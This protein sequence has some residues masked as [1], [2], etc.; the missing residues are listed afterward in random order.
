M[1]TDGRSNRQKYKPTTKA[2]LLKDDGVEIF[3]FG[4]RR[5]INDY[6]LVAIAQIHKFQ[7]E[8]FDDLSFLSHLISSEF[9]LLCRTIWHAFCCFRQWL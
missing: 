5:S 8:R 1:L 2:N 3:T 6:E 7:V 4:I 9:C